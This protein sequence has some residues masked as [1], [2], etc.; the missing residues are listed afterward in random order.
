MGGLDIQGLRRAVFSILP[1]R[2]AAPRRYN[3]FSPAV[4]WG[5]MSSAAAKKQRPK[6]LSLAAILFQIRLPLPG[7]VSILHRVSGALLV[8]PFAAWALYLLDTS[9]RSEQGFS[10]VRDYLGM[11]VAKLGLVVFLWAGCH[12]FCAGIRYL[13]LDLNMGI[14]LRPARISSAL[15]I[16]ASLVLTALFAAKL[17]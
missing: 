17:W 7:W 13:A 15:V 14:A 3:R 2:D 4:G 1:Q 8:V 6:Y 5:S 9:L 16:V 12:H 11:P 10:H